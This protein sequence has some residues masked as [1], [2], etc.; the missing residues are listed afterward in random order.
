MELMSECDSQG[1][2]QKPASWVQN[3]YDIWKFLG[4]INYHVTLTLLMAYWINSNF[5][6]QYIKDVFT[7][8]LLARPV[9]IGTYSIFVTI[10]D[11]HKTY[12]SRKKYIRQHQLDE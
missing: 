9:V 12:V 8:L 3:L 6:T 1:S 5:A 4:V 2:D 7:M 11:A 10:M